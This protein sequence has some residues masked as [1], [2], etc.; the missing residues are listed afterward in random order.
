MGAAIVSTGKRF[1]RLVAKEPPLQ[2]PGAINAYCALLAEKGTRL[3]LTAKWKLNSRL[4]YEWNLSGDMR[5]HAQALGADLRD[6]VAHQATADDSYLG[7]LHLFAS[8]PIG[9]RA[10]AEPTDRRLAR[11]PASEIRN[12]TSSGL[13]KLGRR[14]VAPS[15]TRP[16]AS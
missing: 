16:S 10:V 9:C 15:R 4:R 14:W 8:L 1:R 2:V 6:P 3:P 5:A 11:R 12:R 7:D 13:P